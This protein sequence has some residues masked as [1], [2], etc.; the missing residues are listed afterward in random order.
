MEANQHNLITNFLWGIADDVLRDVYVRGKYRN[1][2]LSM[3]VIGRLA[4][5]LEPTKEAILK[6]QAQMEE[7]RTALIVAALTDKKDLQS[8][9]STTLNPNHYVN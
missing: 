6:I 1:V 4:V 3:T 7:Y 9:V 8:P 5:L 2:I